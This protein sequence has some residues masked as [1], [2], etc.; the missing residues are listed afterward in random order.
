MV[1]RTDA[2]ASW[3]YS[4]AVRDVT[5]VAG[6]CLSVLLSTRVGWR[7]QRRRSGLATDLSSFSLLSR[8]LAGPLARMMTKEGLAAIAV[9]VSLRCS[10]G[11]MVTIDAATSTVDCGVGKR[12]FLSQKL[13]A[14]YLLAGGNKSPTGAVLYCLRVQTS[15]GS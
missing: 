3:A 13:P 11:C 8:L 14:L 1:S 2:T 4:K 7:T 15:V 5:Y 10:E 12:V 6:F 9:T